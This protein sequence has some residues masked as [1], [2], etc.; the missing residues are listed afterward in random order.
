VGQY[1]ERDPINRTV[2]DTSG[3]LPDGTQLKGPDDLRRALAARPDQFVQTL[4][5]RLMTYAL[6]RSV[7]Y[8]DMPTVRHIV[9][10]AA[11]DQYRFSSIV[12]EVVSSDAFRK[13]EASS[14]TPAPALKTAAIEKASAS[15]DAG[16]Q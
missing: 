12:L 1:R 3:T 16:G 2:L 8:H 9:R 5:E 10:T 13:R 6:G 15:S 7:D 11:Q 14:P 4:T